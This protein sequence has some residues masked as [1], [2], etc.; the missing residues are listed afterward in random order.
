MF[1]FSVAGITHG[2]QY[3]PDRN[4][5]E[6]RREERRRER[7]ELEKIE[8][9]SRFEERPKAETGP[10]KDAKGSRIRFI[11]VN[12]NTILPERKIAKTKRKYLGLRGGQNILN[13][14]KELENLYLEKGFIATR[15]KVDMQHTDIKN[16]WIVFQVIEGFVEDIHFKEKK[17]GSTIRIFF[18]PIVSRSNIGSFLFTGTSRNT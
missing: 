2:A 8:R 12:G 13:C 11:I 15:V 4:Q 14:M 10:V 1:T 17:P 18:S 7:E 16:G 3:N 9:R 6:I 5:Q